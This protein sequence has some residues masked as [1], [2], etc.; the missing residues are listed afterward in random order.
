MRALG[1]LA[2]ALAVAGCQT[3]S[4]TVDRVFQPD[5]YVEMADSDVTMAVATMQSVLES[6][7]DG[8]GSG[9]SNPATGNSGRITPERTWQTDAGY[10]CRDFVEALTV[11]GRSADYDRSACRMDDGTWQLSGA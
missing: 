1:V 6:S 10:F 9:W 4:S 7:P 5:L 3:V 2:A 8:S 11:A